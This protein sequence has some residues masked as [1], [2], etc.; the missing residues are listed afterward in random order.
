M[1]NTLKVEVTH[2]PGIAIVK[3]SGE[4]RLQMR[5]LEIEFTRLSA[6]H[7]SAVILDMADLSLVSSLG[8]GLMVSLR[9]SLKHR[10]GR[11]LAAA[12]QPLVLDSFVRA[13]LETIFEVFDSVDAA[14]ASV[15]VLA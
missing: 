7:L 4:A 9:N 2:R 5:P 13:R 1:E 15:S 10:G 3:L 11:L 8:M 14:T 6:E 12:V